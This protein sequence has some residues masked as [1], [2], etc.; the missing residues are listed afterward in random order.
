MV[1]QLTF[2][3]AKNPTLSVRSF[4][5]LILI[6]AFLYTIVNGQPEP[7]QMVQIKAPDGTVRLLKPTAD[8]D[9][10]G[11]ENALEVNGYTYS[12]ID[13]LQT[14]DGDSSKTY[15][16]TDPL[17]WSTDGDPYS[18]YTEVTGVNMHPAVT[19]HT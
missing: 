18:D 11:I 6:V 15:Y 2:L 9:E 12:P 1:S 7:A 13:G 5:L 14:W 17:R 16:I 4:S 19:W 10:D 8:D 3:K